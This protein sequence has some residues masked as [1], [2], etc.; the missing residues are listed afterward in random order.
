MEIHDFI[1]IGG[2]IAGTSAGF[3]LANFGRVLLLERESQFGY[4]STGRSA[5]VFLKS[6]GPGRHPGAGQ[7]KQVFFLE[8]AGG[9]C[10]IPATEKSGAATG[11]RT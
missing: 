5:A 1:V 4:H 11:R 2:G 3:E 6:H 7:R 9:I 10:R 8:P